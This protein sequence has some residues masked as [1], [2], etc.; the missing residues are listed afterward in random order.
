MSDG[1]FALGGRC[2]SLYIAP[3]SG[4]LFGRGHGECPFLR[5]DLVVSEA[6]IAQPDFFLGTFAP[7][8]RASESPI[9]I[10]CFRLCTFPPLP[11]FPDL[12]DPF[13]R[14]RIALLTDLPAVRPY[15]AIVSS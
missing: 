10:A 9:A 2:R 1:S 7:F 12:K 8:F 13:F 15:L 6:L 14:R 4:T 11:P 5:T 3:C